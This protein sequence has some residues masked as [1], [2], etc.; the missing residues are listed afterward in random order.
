MAASVERWRRRQVRRVVALV[1]LPGLLLGAAT[2]TGAY[3]AGL[4]DRHAHDP[5]CPVSLVAVPTRGSF[6]VTVLNGSGLSGKARSAAATLKS[7]GFKV[8]RTGNAPERQWHDEVA[9][10]WHGPQGSAQAQLVAAEI[11]GSRLALDFRPG[12]GVDVVVGT[13]YTADAVGATVQNAARLPVPA[14]GDCATDATTASG[15][16]E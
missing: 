11:P 13:A 8:E 2:A 3:A 4:F 14:A 16:Y 6:A 9:I 1:C 12:P 5:A 10:I 7:R 15:H